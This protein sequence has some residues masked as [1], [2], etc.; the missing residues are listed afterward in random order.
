[1]LPKD[2]DISLLKTA[3]DEAIADN[4]SAKVRQ[5][6]KIKTPFLKT[7]D[8]PRF[9]EYADDYPIM[10]RFN[11]NMRPDVIGPNGQQIKE[12]QE[13]D[14]VYAGRWARVSVRP[15]FYDHPTGGKGVSLGLQNVQVLGHGD[16]IA[17]SKPRG[18]SEF[19][20]VTDDLGDLE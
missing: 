3:V 1:L 11:A 10:L 6:T 13:A 5:T 16:A 7:A 4:V 19:A 12:E 17:G 2:A 18:S 20:A 9:A 8:Q 14:E 15:F